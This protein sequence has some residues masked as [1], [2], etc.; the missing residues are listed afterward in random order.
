MKFSKELRARLTPIVTTLQP[1]ARVAER[2]AHLA[3]HMQRPTAVGV[4]G[5]AASGIAT[6]A[7]ELGQPQ[8]YRASIDTL[9]SRGQLMA[10]IEEAGGS[11]VVH[12][13]KDNEIV[14]CKVHQTPFS[15]GENSSIIGIGPDNAALVEWLRQALDR[16]LPMHIEVRRKQ[17][18]DSTHYESI[19]FG[20]SHHHNAQATAI[21]KSTLPLLEGGRCILLD[22]KPG[23]GKTTMAQI[24]ARDAG[25]GRTVMLENT[26]FGCER[27][28]HSGSVPASSSNDFRDALAL[29]SPGV[30]VVD[31]IDKVHLSLSRVEALRSSARLVILT[32][33]NGQY[34][35]VLD[36]A[37]MRAGR[38]DEVFTIEP[39]PVPRSAPFDQLSDQ[40]WAEV[41]QWPVAYM[42]EVRK[43]LT[44]R[45][46][47]MRLDDLRARLTR[48]TRS[49]D[50][51]L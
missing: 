4:L 25:L 32:A 41:S 38:V 6:L 15:I 1:V 33:N 12:R 49:G 26:L 2:M 44:H 48:K 17:D 9:V 13:N 43:R 11:V 35:E 29:L 5:L 24:I 19:P 36:G 39:A 31:D 14:E 47:D 51:L 8:N 10:A 22:G 50:K 21:L 30:V 7:Q 18:R 46:A 16:V 40:E 45:A 20:L 34:D 23:V 28:A 42:N 37:L 27:D 3:V